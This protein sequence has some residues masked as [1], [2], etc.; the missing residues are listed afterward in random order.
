MYISM[1]I[2]ILTSLHDLFLQ[3]IQMSSERQILLKSGNSFVA[4]VILNI[5]TPGKQGCVL[6]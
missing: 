6:K 3:G 5:L 2:I 1:I 4:I